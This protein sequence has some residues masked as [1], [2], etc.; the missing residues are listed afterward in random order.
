M[1]ERLGGGIRFVYARDIPESEANY[2]K[3]REA[4]GYYDTATGEVVV[5]L[6][7]HTSKGVPSVIE[8][9][10]TVMHEVVGH[11][12][13]RGLLGEEGDAF[14]DDVYRGMKARSKAELE[15]KYGGQLTRRVGE[16]EADFETR[17]R[18]MPYLTR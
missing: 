1:A 16:S 11:K 13:V 6:D 10:K 14:F 3:K 18:R 12:G 7:N 5:V 8:V 4:Y 17:R 9:A 15:S 2:K